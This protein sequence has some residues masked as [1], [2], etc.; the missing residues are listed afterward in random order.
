[1]LI[2]IDLN[3]FLEY[4]PHI[5]LGSLFLIMTTV[6]ISGIKS[7]REYGQDIIEPGTFQKLGMIGTMIGLVYVFYEFDI[8]N[9]S[10]MIQGT[11]YAIFSTLI[12]LVFDQ[13]YLWRKRKYTDTITSDDTNGL[14]QKI[15]DQISQIQS[16][17][18]E[19]NSSE[20][21]LEE[22]K[23][24]RTESN[25]NLLSIKNEMINFTQKLAKNNTEALI[26]AVKNVMRDFNSK[27]NDNLGDTFKQLNSSVENLVKWQ[28]DYKDYLDN[29]DKNL[30]M[31][32]NGI[33]SSDETLENIS[34]NLISL[35][36]SVNS[37]GELIKQIGVIT[38]YQKQHVNE[39]DDRLIAF[40]E[41]K[42]KAINAFP[43]I[44]NN[45]ENITTRL[46][47]DMTNVSNS[48]KESSDRLTNVSEKQ[49]KHLNDIAENMD[50]NISNSISTMNQNITKVNEKIS[51]NIDIQYKDL[52]S[53]LKISMEDNANALNASSKMHQEH[54]NQI[55]GV[56]KDKI[57]QSTK[58]LDE[59]VLVHMKKIGN[60]ISAQ[61]DW[62]NKI[63]MTI[64]TNIK[65]S[66]NN[67][68]EVVEEQIKALS[69]STKE[70]IRETNDSFISIMEK[71][72][73]NFENLDKQMQHEI[74][75][76]LQILVNKM[77]GFNSEFVK[78]HGDMIRTISS[79][80]NDLIERRRQ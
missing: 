67:I 46:D 8:S 1:V 21:L 30:R 40:S 28:S 12:G 3:I 32:L 15:V 73:G 42:D 39:L 69:K 53:H 31:A 47:S 63:V 34:H 65:K 44:Q 79:S 45:L 19:I 64:D 9:I 26:E 33:K 75:K 27:I 6:L 76:A 43:L 51:E 7:L 17:I 38:D 74:T 11:A 71:L 37:L 2:Q 14:I 68:N 18:P 25:N 50:T 62:I 13:I 72:D 80:T 36:E 58:G 56:V 22:I 54:I 16:K 5:I 24:G 70:M 77:T 55:C 61:E 66:T 52:N 59:A 57:D 60:S 78:V 49:I 48:I 4:F 10:T 29:Y 35:P 41:M 23:L 20:L